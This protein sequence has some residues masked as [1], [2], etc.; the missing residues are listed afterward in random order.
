MLNDIGKIGV[1]DA[2]LNKPGLLNEEEWEVMRRH[3]VTGAK[4]L[5]GISG[6]ERVADA[7]DKHHERFDGKGYPRGIAGEEIP[8][9]AR[10][11]SVVDAF[12]AMTN[13]RPYRGAMGREE[14][15]EELARESGKQFD[16]TVVGVLRGLLRGPA[17]TESEAGEDA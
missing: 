17:E 11:I 16:P 8:V 2:V 1:P 4:I 12:D 6:F 9:E 14:A 15:L 5:S 3:P 13:D 7:V 10:I